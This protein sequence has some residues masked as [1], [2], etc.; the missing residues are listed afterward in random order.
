MR[1]YRKLVEKYKEEEKIFYKNIDLLRDVYV[2]AYSAEMFQLAR[3]II[4]EIIDYEKDHTA[5][6]VSLYRKTT[7]LYPPLPIYE[8]IDLMER[9]IKNMKYTN[10]EIPEFVRKLRLKIKNNTSRDRKKL[11]TPQIK[12]KRSV[13]SK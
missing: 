3:D 1:D 4:E 9:S 8:R 10:K 13:K 7:E 2:E 5:E 6:S 11:K 12:R